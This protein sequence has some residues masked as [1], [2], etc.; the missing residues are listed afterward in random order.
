MPCGAKFGSHFWR[1]NNLRQLNNMQIFERATTTAIGKN[2]ETRQNDT[3][4]MCRFGK[5]EN[6]TPGPVVSC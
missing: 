1:W 6:G 3:D 4:N 2:R 5:P